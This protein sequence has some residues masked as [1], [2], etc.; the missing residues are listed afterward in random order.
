MVFLVDLIVMLFSYL[1]VLGFID[2]DTGLVYYIQ[3]LYS[4]FLFLT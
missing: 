4:V 2:Y 3:I 1:L